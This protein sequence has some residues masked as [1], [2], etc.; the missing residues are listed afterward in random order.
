MREHPTANNT[1]KFAHLTVPNRTETPQNAI[2]ILTVQNGRPW[3]SSGRPEWLYGAQNA[4]AGPELSVW[5]R[6]LR[7]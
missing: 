3:R 1:Q 5:H 2:E 4:S 6:T 7:T